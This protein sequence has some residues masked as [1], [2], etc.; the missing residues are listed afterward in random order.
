MCFGDNM[1]YKS[2]FYLHIGA[3]RWQ[4]NYLIDVVAL[5]VVMSFT[6]DYFAVKP[7]IYH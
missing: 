1:L 3:D 2:T 5:I 7:C 6:V 4:D